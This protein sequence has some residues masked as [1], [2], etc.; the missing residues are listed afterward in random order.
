MTKS[1]MEEQTAYCID[2]DN[3]FVMSNFVGKYTCFE[4]DFKDLV[5]DMKSVVAYI[6]NE[7]RPYFITKRYDKSLGKPVLKVQSETQ[8]SEELTKNFTRYEKI[9]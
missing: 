1:P 5:I 2:F 3:T 4:P 6:C 7:G 9:E 8:L